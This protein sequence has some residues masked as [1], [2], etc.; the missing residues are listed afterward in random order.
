MFIPSDFATPGEDRCQSPRDSH[1]R[2][3]CLFLV[4]R[5]SL[6]GIV[7]T[8]MADDFVL[9]GVLVVQGIVVET[10]AIVLLNCYVYIK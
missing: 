3:G 10:V 4:L 6:D 9:F 2:C 7:P 8:S 1:G 5:T